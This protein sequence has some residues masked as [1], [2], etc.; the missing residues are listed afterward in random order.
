MKF[1][2]QGKLRAALRLLEQNR[3][4]GVLSLNSTLQV[5]PMQQS[6]IREILVDKHPPGQPAHPETVLNPPIPTLDPYPIL[7]DRL[8]GAI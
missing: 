6:T 4:S 2:K 8:D 7:F 1:M 5:G 3:G